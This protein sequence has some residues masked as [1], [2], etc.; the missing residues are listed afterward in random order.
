MSPF[1]NIESPLFN[2]ITDKL[3]DVLKRPIFDLNSEEKKRLSESVDNLDELLNNI[4]WTSE[5]TIDTKK[6]IEDYN[7]FYY[8]IDEKVA[9]FDIV[10]TNK[11]KEKLEDEFNT[12]IE[13]DTN[14]DE[15]DA[16]HDTKAEIMNTINEHILDLDNMYDAICDSKI[17]DY[18]TMY[19]S[20][21]DF[22]DLEGN[23]YSV[24]ING[25][26]N[27]DHNH[28]EDIEIHLSKNNKDINKGIININYGGFDSYDYFENEAENPENAYLSSR[29]Y[30]LNETVE[31]VIKEIIET[32]NIK[33][34]VLKQV[35][36]FIE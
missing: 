29:I 8:I 6:L 26:L 2:L 1:R 31:L 21:A 10:Q 4:F 14:L 17:L 5:F 33:I 15:D 22:K 27:P 35:N 13:I 19:E 20:L 18:F 23:E 9:E 24:Y 25:S 3:F 34:N 16:L 30:E 32:M 28:N 7:E 11:L 12:K 36:S